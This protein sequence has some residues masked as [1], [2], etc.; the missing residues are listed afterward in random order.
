M[1][2]DELDQARA[3]RERLDV[4]D[5]AEDETAGPCTGEPELSLSEETE[6]AVKPHNGCRGVGYEAMLAAAI[7]DS[8]ND[9]KALAKNRIIVRGQCVKRWPKDRCGI[10]KVFLSYY[11]APAKVKELLAYLTKGGME[12]DLKLLGSNIKMGKALDK[13]GLSGPV[14]KAPRPPARRV[15]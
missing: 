14:A 10:N 11:N 6:E 8:V 9:C 4:L 3:N 13:L 15:A 2:D 1:Y 5:V 12:C 7:K